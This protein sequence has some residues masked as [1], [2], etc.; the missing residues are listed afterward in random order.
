MK[1]P[2]TR[3]T[4]RPASG[5]GQSRP[6]HSTADA[7]MLDRIRA[8]AAIVRIRQE[9]LYDRL[10]DRFQAALEEGVDRSPE[11]LRIAAEKARGLLVS[12]GAMTPQQGERLKEFLLR[13]RDPADTQRRTGDV[14]AAG[15]LA[16]VNCGGR[17]Q[18]R[19]TGTVPPCPKCA[20]TEFLR[21]D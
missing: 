17:M 8:A 19:K 18:F 7:R 16:C 3:A 5:N 10:A 11:S 13:D 15:T 12:S 6:A 20:T 9:G 14:T 1:N 2:E 21:G 4:A